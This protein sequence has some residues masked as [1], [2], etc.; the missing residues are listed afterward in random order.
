VRIDARGV[1]EAGLFVVSAASLSY[2]AFAL[3][4][5]AAFGRR[6]VE[7]DHATPPVTVLKPLHGAEPLLAEKL[8]SFCDQDYPAYEVILGTRDAGDAALMV[9]RDVAASLNSSAGRHARVRIVSADENAP[10]HANPKADTLAGMVPHARGELLAIADSDMRVD[11]NWLR[12]I[13]APFAD[14]QV[15]AVTCLYRGE[16]ADDGLA[17]ALGAMANH[18]HFAPS[19][20]VAQALGPPRYTFGA[21]MAVRRE[22]F[23]AIGGLAALGTHLADDARLGELVARRGLRVH[24]S[25]YVVANVVAEPGLRALWEHEVRWARTHRTLRPGGYAGLLL[26]YPLPLAVLY[27]AAARGR[28]RRVALAALGIAAALRFAL[29]RA[30]GDAFGARPVGPAWLVPL[31]DALG[32]AVWVAA[33]RSRGVAW[34]GDAFTVRADGTLMP[35]RTGP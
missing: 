20:L 16:P 31:R 6:P 23:E 21:T 8:R 3:S 12:A 24:L 4:R 10:R 33:Y 26:T 25:R 14:P 30:A 1:A 18:E 5:V 28:R 19:V 7:R 9:A 11:P 22:V 17:S 15:G 13:A 29:R 32:L 34:S 2:T 27:L 35:R